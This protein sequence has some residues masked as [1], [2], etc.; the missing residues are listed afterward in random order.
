M[1]IIFLDVDGVIRLYKEGTSSKARDII[2]ES[3]NL[4]SSS[5]NNLKSIITSTGAKIVLTSSWRLVDKNSLSKLFAR[6]TFYKIYPYHFIGKTPS[7]PNK[8]RGYEIY[9]F[10]ESRKDIEE[11]IILDYSAIDENYFP[12]N[13]FIKI[14]GRVGIT[15]EIKQLCIKRLNKI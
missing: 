13:N 15:E 7:Y 5:C 4:D 2:E 3:L 14:D 12:N 10:I 6:L 9:E 11:Y 1:K 8:D